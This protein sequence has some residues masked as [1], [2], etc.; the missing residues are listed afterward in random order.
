MVFSGNPL[1]PHPHLQELEKIARA[2]G[3][4]SA[5]LHSGRTSKSLES[6]GFSSHMLGSGILIRQLKIVMTYTTSLRNINGYSVQSIDY[7]F[8]QLV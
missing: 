4:M 2:V 8:N 5:D 7:Q 6:Q 1:R 3:R